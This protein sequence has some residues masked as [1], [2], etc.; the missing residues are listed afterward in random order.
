MTMAALVVVHV[1]PM[2]VAAADKVLHG[3]VFYRRFA[4]CLWLS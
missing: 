3:V 1:V 4:C 2:T